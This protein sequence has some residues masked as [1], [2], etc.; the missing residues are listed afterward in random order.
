M[1]KTSKIFSVILALTLVFAMAI[2]AFAADVA[3][4]KIT[5]NNAVDGQAYSIYKMFSF[6][7]AGENEGVYTVDSDWQAFVDGAGASYVKVQNGTV[8]WIG[9]DSAESK[10]AFAKAALAYAE[11]KNLT[12][13]ATE[14]ATG[15]TVEFTNLALGY[16]LVDSSLGSLCALDTTNKTATVDEKNDVPTLVKKIVEGEARV[17]ANNVAIGDTVNYEV[18]IAAKAGAENY[19]MHD[20]MSAGLDLVADSI[21]V[22][23]LTKGTDYT[24]KTADFA[25]DCDFEIE[26]SKTYLD[27]LKADTEIV[28]TYSATLNSNAVVGTTGNPN[29]AW[30]EYGN[31]IDVD[32]DGTPDEEKPETPE[33]IVITYTTELVVDKTDGKNPLAGAQFTL[34][35]AAGK[36]YAAVVSEDGTK[37]T[38]TGL[39]EGT[40]TLS[41][42]V[43]PTGYNKADDITVEITCTEPETVDAET[44]TATWTD[45]HDDVAEANGKFST[46]VVN[47]TGSLLPST[48]GIGTTI[49]YIVGALLVVGAVVLLITKKKTSVEA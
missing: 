4:G 39:K 11:E 7:S 33:D 26:F 43:V 23:G 12:A 15:T 48:G 40:Y 9:G 25:D 16:Y 42:T 6:A 22:A 29:T 2:P 38:W 32:G 45:D 46:I 13:T 47:S 14:V 36:T 20:R 19:V 27:S 30:L 5:V 3:D 28:V 18:K 24:V 41:E 17:D 49:F 37:F 21:A 10:A 1:K 34:K 35:D 8:E 31:E 44:N